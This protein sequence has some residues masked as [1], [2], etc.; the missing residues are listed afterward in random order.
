MDETQLLHFERPKSRDLVLDSNDKDDTDDQE[1]GEDREEETGN[2]QKSEEINIQFPSLKSS[3]NNHLAITSGKGNQ[4]LNEDLKEMSSYSDTSQ[5]RFEENCRKEMT[6]E[7]YCGT[8]SV[9][10]RH[11]KMAFCPK[12]VKRI[13]EMEELSKKNAQSH[14]IRKII[15]FSYLGIR[16]GCEDMYE[17]DLNHFSI[18]Q[19]GESYVDQKNPGVSF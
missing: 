19:K 17:L 15:V 1:E 9:Q 5:M 7:G 18:L 2:M 11:Q 14:T 4:K 8:A 6:V 16:H 12:E 13:L 3:L 10:R